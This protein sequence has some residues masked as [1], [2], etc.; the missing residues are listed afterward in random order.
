MIAYIY[1]QKILYYTLTNILYNYLR[2]YKQRGFMKLTSRIPATLEQLE[3]RCLDPLGYIPGVSTV[4]G[5]A[6]TVLAV[7]QIVS[8]TV[9]AIIGCVSAARNPLNQDPWQFK[10]A[11]DAF[12]HGCANL[13]RGWVEIIPLINMITLAFDGALDAKNDH[14]PFSK[15]GRL[16]YL[17][18]SQNNLLSDNSINS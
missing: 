1:T 6:R 5:T 17:L 7:A 15:P 16:S 18:S 10:W 11:A 8:A 3:T 14:D 4:T 9:L 13:A 12:C 2:F